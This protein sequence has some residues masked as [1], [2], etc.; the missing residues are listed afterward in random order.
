MGIGGHCS[1]EAEFHHWSLSLFWDRHPRRGLT[2]L[3]DLGQGWD[4]GPLRHAQRIED[5][6]GSVAVRVA[7]AGVGY[8]DEWRLQRALG[9]V[10]SIE[11]VHPSEP[12]GVPAL[13]GIATPVS[14]S[15]TLNVLAR[16]DGVDAETGSAIPPAG[17][18][19][20]S[21]SSGPRARGRR[22]AASSMPSSA[23][24]LGRRTK[25]GSVP[26][27]TLAVRTMTE[28][29]AL[30]GESFP[31]TDAVP[32]DT[33]SPITTTAER[34]TRRTAPPKVIALA[35]PR[36]RCPRRRRRS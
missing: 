20:R 27:R 8:R 21:S 12:V 30:A 5:V 29:S 16:S 33:R 6:T 14:V 4:E 10:E 23:S 11:D 2:L 32:A 15:I 7:G 35:C 28:T 36:T 24:P 13:A 26:A 25:T 31:R 17:R 34:S 1:G 18:K 9:D 19:M 3:H 22:A